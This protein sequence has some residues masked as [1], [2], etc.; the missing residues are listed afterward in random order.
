[1]E[2][3]EQEE[4][5]GWKSL[6]ALKPPSVASSSAELWQCCSGAW[7]SPGLDQGRLTMR[8]VASPTVRTHC[9]VQPWSGFPFSGQCLL[10]RIATQSGWLSGLKKSYFSQQ[11]REMRK[12]VTTEIRE[13]IF[14]LQYSN[15]MT[16]NFLLWSSDEPRQVNEVGQW[17]NNSYFSWM[18]LHRSRVSVQRTQDIN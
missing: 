2:D 10:S 5:Q 16:S 1:M 15:P 3:S 9:R 7:L 4:R 6:S 17:F 14:I 11:A 18:F 8:N 12:H 13:G